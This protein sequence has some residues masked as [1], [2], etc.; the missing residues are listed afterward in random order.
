MKPT[1]TAK[2]LGPG[3]TNIIWGGETF[4]VPVC[5]PNCY[6]IWEA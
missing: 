1:Q 4:R 3:Y 5:G 6:I 2:S